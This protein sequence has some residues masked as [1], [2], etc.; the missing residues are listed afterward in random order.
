MTKGEHLNY[1][2]TNLGT[3]LEVQRLRLS[4]PNVR[5]DSLTPNQ[6]I[7][8]PQPKTK[9]INKITYFQALFKNFFN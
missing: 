7:K 9:L 6:R 5:H 3:F 4:V 2:V 8:I 1:I